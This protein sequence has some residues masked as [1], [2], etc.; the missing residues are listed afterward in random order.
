MEITTKPLTE[1]LAGTRYTA[2]DAGT[3][4]GWLAVHESGLI[5]DLEVAIGHRGEGIATD[6][7][8]AACAAGDVYH[9]PE[10]ACTSDGSAFV[11]AVGGDVM[12]SEEAAAI[13]EVDLAEILGEDEEILYGEYGEPLAA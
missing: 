10:W 13:L 5:L 9:A 7:Y 4:V 6:L 11:S 8:E 12:D 1:D 3:E 2:I